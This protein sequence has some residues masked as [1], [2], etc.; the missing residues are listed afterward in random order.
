MAPCK[1]ALCDYFVAIFQVAQNRLKFGMSTLFVLK[2]VCFYLKNA[3]KYGQNCV[4]F[5]PPP[6][7]LLSVSKQRRISI[8]ESQNTVRVSCTLLVAWWG[9]GGGGGGGG[10]EKGGGLSRMCLKPCFPA[11]GEKFFFTE[12]ELACQ[13]SADSELLGKSLQNSHIG[14]TCMEPFNWHHPTDSISLLVKMDG[15]ES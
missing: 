2:N 10:C 1:P 3:E 4:K 14:P 11:C 6:P 12:K 9:G 13:I 7:P 5:N 15:G 8:L